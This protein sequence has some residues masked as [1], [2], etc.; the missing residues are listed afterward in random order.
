M[1]NTYLSF[2][3]FQRKC[4]C[5]MQIDSYARMQTK[6]AIDFQRCSKEE[7]HESTIYEATYTRISDS[8]PLIISCTIDK[9][10]NYSYK[11]ITKP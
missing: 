4:P 2:N 5:Y 11:V 1:L 7:L 6:D 8:R 10:K 9:S 3:E